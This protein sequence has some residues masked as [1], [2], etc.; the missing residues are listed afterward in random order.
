MTS[1]SASPATQKFLGMDL[2]SFWRDLRTAW[3]GMLEWR[4][5]AW[6]WP[7][8]AVR[9]WLPGG[10]QVLCRNIKVAPTVDEA[11]SRA[12]R[13]EAVLLPEDL[14]LRRTLTLPKLQVADLQAALAL[15][16]Q[17]L[18][19]FQSDDTVWTHTTSAQDANSCQVHLVL[20]ARKLITH[21]LALHYLHLKVSP[22][23]VW[24]SAQGGPGYLV[25]PG[26]GGAMR[27]RR[28]AMWRGASAALC[29]LL[30]ALVAALAV[31]PS[32]QLYLRALHANHALMLLQKKV[33]PVVA[34][35]ESL[36]RATEQLDSLAK[37]VGQ[38]VPVLQ[39][40]DLV[41]RALPD[42]TSLLSFKVNGLKVS[43]SGQT[44]NSA[45]LMKQL[46]AT[47]GLKDVK[48]PTAA[49][50]PLGAARESFSI[51]FMLSPDQLGPAP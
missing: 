13:F 17:S 47:P 16:V 33:S 46:G 19:P 43:I 40:L 42:D 14:L 9:L 39:T 8:I 20:S 37:L 26:F 25:M 32:V 7:D 12:A 1:S 27:A 11:G 24:V 10:A 34:Q 35:R 31:T 28:G 51:E 48:A 36:L 22:V 4:V 38:P 44:G 45:T 41:T 30:L 5:L 2:A 29:L 6:L 3:R 49:V 50:K 18:S 15:E 23:E 21:H